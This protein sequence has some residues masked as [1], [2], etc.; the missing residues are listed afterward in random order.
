GILGLWNETATWFRTDRN[1]KIPDATLSSDV[2]PEYLGLGY[3][4]G[5]RIAG[6]LASGGVLSWLALIP[7][8]SIFVPEPRLVEDLQRLGYREAWKA[9][10]SHAQ[11]IYFAYVRYVG[12]GAVAC[13]GVMTLLK[14]LPTIVSA[15]GESVKAMRGGAGDR[16]PLRTE[17][18]LGMGFV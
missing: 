1:G 2:T 17:D 4:I 9:S 5:P 12:A 14:T 8:I 16:K 10:H 6:E 18:D 7:L 3:I 15:F 13:A 11:W